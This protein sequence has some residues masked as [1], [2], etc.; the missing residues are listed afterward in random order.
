[1]ICLACR[2]GYSPTCPLCRER[3]YRVAPLVL[4]ADK[5][6]FPWTLHR[7]IWDS[8]K[9]EGMHCENCGKRIA[10]EMTMRELFGPCSAKVSIGEKPSRTEGTR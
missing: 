9:M 4:V 7:P 2:T 6:Q 5:D 3:T 1:M 10:P 8:P